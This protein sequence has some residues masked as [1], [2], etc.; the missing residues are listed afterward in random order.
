[1]ADGPQAER[2]G[3]TV[4]RHVRASVDTFVFD[5]DDTLY[6]RA[7]QLHERMVARAVQFIASLIGG[8]E[9]EAIALHQHYYTVYGTS[10]V[11][12]QKHQG[13]APLD[14][15]RFVHDIDL[16]PIAPNAELTQAIAA[17]PGRRVVFTN[18]SAAHARRVLGHLGLSH[19]FDE[20]CDIEACGFI[21]KPAQAAYD[22]LFLRHHIDPNR[23]IM[24]DD[25]HVNLV[26]PHGVGMQTVLI[27]ESVPTDADHVHFQT[28]DLAQFLAEHWRS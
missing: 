11:G 26:V 5:L 22:A 7:S 10:L 17:L 4:Q 19:L 14:Y 28:T 12:L 1:M 18:G 2:I 16:S 13:I 23:A 3:A 24:F 20:V 8:T 27:G 21:G 15:M 25:R 9:A 6:P